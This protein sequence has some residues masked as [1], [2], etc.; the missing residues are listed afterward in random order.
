MATARVAT[1]G[2]SVAGRAIHIKL[3]PRSRN[4]AESRQ[5]LRVL[6]RY[7]EVVMYKHLKV[8]FLIKYTLLLLI[9]PLWISRSAR[10]WSWTFLHFKFDLI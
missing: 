3:F 4:I 7:G 8:L 5:V 1:S 10:Y 6:E 9:P 2:L